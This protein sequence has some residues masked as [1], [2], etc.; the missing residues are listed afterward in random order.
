MPTLSPR[1]ATD[2]ILTRNRTEKLG[3]SAAGRAMAAR[4]MLAAIPVTTLIWIAVIVY[5]VRG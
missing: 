2:P 4:A 3:R 1:E 5:L